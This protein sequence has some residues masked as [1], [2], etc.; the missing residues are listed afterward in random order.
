VTRKVKTSNC[1]SCGAIIVWTR[2]SRGKNVP[3]NVDS[4]EERDLDWLEPSDTVRDWTP[5]F[6]YGTHEPHFKTCSERQE[7]SGG[8][9]Q[10]CARLERELAAA[11]KELNELKPQGLR[12]PEQASLED[13]DIPF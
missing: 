10:N 11:R 12:E 13:D 8:D 4:I 2:S 9:C 3:V 1:R 7:R 5:K 6:V